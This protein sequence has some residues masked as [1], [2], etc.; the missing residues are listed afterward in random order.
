MTWRKSSRSTQGTSG[1][2]VEVAR[3]G[4]T[5]GVRDSKQPHAS[6]LILT[7][8]KFAVVLQRLKDVK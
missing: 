7:T 3:F 4:K 2:C 6:H 8:A 1:E 5:I